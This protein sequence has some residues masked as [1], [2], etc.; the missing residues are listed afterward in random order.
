[1]GGAPDTAGDR[2]VDLAT[3]RQ[4]AQLAQMAQDNTQSNDSP[5]NAPNN[6]VNFAKTKI[7]QVK[8]ALRNRLR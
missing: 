8:Q 5:L 1:M 2:A 6:P 7:E 3:R 4:V